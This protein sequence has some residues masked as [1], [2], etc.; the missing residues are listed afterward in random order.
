MENGKNQP[1]LAHFKG[2]QGKWTAKELQILARRTLVLKLH[3][4][5]STFDQI[6][7]HLKLKGYKGSSRSNVGKDLNATLEAA[8]SEFTLK[9]ADVVQIELERLDALTLSL[10]P[11]TMRDA[12]P[13]DVEAVLHIMDRRARY[14]GLDKPQMHEVTG[15]EGG[16]I[17][18][19]MTH[20]L[21][22]LSDAELVALKT[23]Q[24]KLS[25]SENAS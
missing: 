16:P 15:A 18:T 1:K 14:L 11:R 10:W 7:Q 22:K 20:D 13:K 6:S 12:Y 9:A 24:S 5:G 21:S 4:A 19:R 23:I 17:E 25:E 2:G 8:R 3:L